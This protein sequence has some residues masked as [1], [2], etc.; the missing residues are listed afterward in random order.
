MVD[1]KA[2]LVMNLNY[3]FSDNVINAFMRKNKKYKKKQ[4]KKNNFYIGKAEFRRLRLSPGNCKS[5]GKHPPK[6]LTP[7]LLYNSN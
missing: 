5:I 4:I 3:A 7:A 1:Q 2:S 6:G